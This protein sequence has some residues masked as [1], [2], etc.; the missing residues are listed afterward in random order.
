MT[1]YRTELEA[2]SSPNNEYE[3]AILQKY[4]QHRNIEELKVNEQDYSRLARG[5]SQGT[6]VETKDNSRNTDIPIALS[7]DTWEQPLSAFNGSYPHNHVFETRNGLIE[8]FDDTEGNERYHRYHPSGTFIEWD[9]EGNSV[10][11]TI[12]DSYQIIEKNGMVYIK[13]D[14][15]LT[16]EG[17]CKILVMNDC[18]LEVK[19]S[20]VGLVEN[21]INLTTNGCMNLNVKETLKIRADNMVFESSKFNHKNVGIYNLTT[22]SM[23]QVVKENYSLTIG[24]YSLTTSEDIIL[25]GGGKISAS[26]DMHL[27]NKLYVK[28]EVHCETFKGTIQR[29]LYADGAN[30]ASSAVIASTLSTAIPPT[31]VS[32]DPDAPELTAALETQVAMSTGLVIPGDRAVISYPNISRS[33]P[34]TRLTKIAIEN[35]GKDSVDYALYP[36]YSR[37]APYFDPDA[38]NENTNIETGRAIPSS[39]GSIYRAPA[40]PITNPINDAYPS[41]IISKYFTIGDL[42]SRATF[43][44]NLKEQC[45]LTE[46]EIARNLQH[47]STNILDKLV[48]EYGRP[49]FIIT[50]GFRTYSGKG[51]TSQHDIGQAVDIQFKINI[52]DYSSRGEEL[53]KILTFDQLLLE[54]Q[55]GGTGKPW[56]HISYDPK[57]TRRQ[58]ATYYNH[59]PVTDFK[60]V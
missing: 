45:G 32:P 44:H 3:T 40:I 21:D 24:T 12:G 54:Y 37:K 29:A 23:D 17:A 59:K 2:L 26:T 49:S 60:V 51:Q 18:N 27:E 41:T 56:F 22:N 50:S 58:Y 20:L 39:F 16:V 13:G 53:I 1:L 34:N 48:E 55:S 36:G 10:R 33:P 5:I 14:C 35:D 25:N 6:V 9:S 46:L 28:E 38:Q 8:E 4:P 11:K 47:L 30:R 43:P 7:M 31:E 19:G 42:T 15:N 52:N 57:R